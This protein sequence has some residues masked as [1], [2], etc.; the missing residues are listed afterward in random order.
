MDNEQAARSLASASLD[1]DGINSMFASQSLASELA[2]TISQLQRSQSDDKPTSTVNS[3]SSESQPNMAAMKALTDQQNAT[4][5]QIIDQLFNFVQKILKENESL[6]A[7]NASYKLSSNGAS[8]QVNAERESVAVSPNKVAK[9]ADHQQKSASLDPSVSKHPAPAKLHV[10]GEQNE[11]G[12]A[13]RKI[14]NQSQQKISDIEVRQRVRRTIMINLPNGERIRRVQSH[15][16]V[17]MGHRDNV[18][19]AVDW[20]G[21]DHEEATLP[22][23]PIENIAGYER[24]P[25]EVPAAIVNPYSDDLMVQVSYRLQPVVEPQ[26]KSVAKPLQ[27]SHGPKIDVAKLQQSV[28]DTQLSTKQASRVSRRQVARNN[29][30]LSSFDV[31]SLSLAGIL[32]CAGNNVSYELND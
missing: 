2:A 13:A 14:A 16:F 7:E 22:A 4:T 3:R 21:W 9:M 18:T 32:G 17:R 25:K 29:K 8:S 1:K 10:V 30:Q 31:L 28:D 20:D 6:A 26:P 23:Y 27:A 24:Q 11:D 5:G 12:N 19:G 15:T